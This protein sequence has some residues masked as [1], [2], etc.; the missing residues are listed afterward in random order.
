LFYV[1]TGT[2][3]TNNYGDIGETFYNSLISALADFC[4]GLMKTMDPAAPFDRLSSKNFHEIFNLAYIH[5]LPHYV[6]SGG[7]RKRLPFPI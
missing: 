1:E 6:Q 4:K 7:N 2:R 5:P 3:F